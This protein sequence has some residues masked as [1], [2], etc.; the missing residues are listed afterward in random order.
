M[1]GPP[2][3]TPGGPTNLKTVLARNRFQSVTPCCASS[4][5][6]I[7]L[8]IA[9][10]P[11]PTSLFSKTITIEMARLGIVLYWTA[12]AIAIALVVLAVFAYF[13]ATGNGALPSAGLIVVFASLI[14][15][16]GLAILYVLAGR[17]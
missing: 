1:K 3:S 17:R 10:P 14:W 6:N 4:L 9:G 8:P 2:R 11:L 13:T 15:L 5:V 12:T 7:W 16:T